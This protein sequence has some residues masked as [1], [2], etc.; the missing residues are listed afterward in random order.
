MPHISCPCGTPGHAERGFGLGRGTAV[1]WLVQKASSGKLMLEAVM[2]IVRPVAE[3]NQLANGDRS[4]WPQRGSMVPGDSQI[5][6]LRV[7]RAARR[8]DGVGLALETLEYSFVGGA[9]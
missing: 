1:W 9:S 2:A 6:M 8:V 7:A 4:G 3:C 5:R